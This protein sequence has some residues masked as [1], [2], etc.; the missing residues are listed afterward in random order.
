MLPVVCIPLAEHFGNKC[1]R[2]CVCLTK[3]TEKA[4][5]KMR[6]EISLTIMSSEF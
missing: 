4:W 5:E 2:K 1:R 3:H 6:K